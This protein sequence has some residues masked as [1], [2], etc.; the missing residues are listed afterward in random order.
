MTFTQYADFYLKIKAQEIK[1]SSFAK[2]QS[3]VKYYMLP[4]FSSYSIKEA[5]KM[6]T[7][8][9]FLL[10]I[11]NL[12]PK[13]AVTPKFRKDVILVLRG[14]LQEAFYDEAIQKN[15]A[16]LIR[17][18]KAQKPIINPFASHEVKNL[19][20]T[21]HGYFK[22]FLAVSFYTGVRTG[23]AMALHVSDI[24]FKNNVIHI[25]KT[26]GKYGESTPKTFSS[27]RDVPLF[28]TL[29]PFLIEYLKTHDNEY[30]FVNQYGNPFN[31]SKNLT[32]RHFHPLLDK[33][34]LQRR[35]LY[36]TRHTFAT[37]MLESGKFSVNEIARFMGHT[38]TQ[39]I[40]NRY[41]KFIE[42]ERRKVKTNVDIYSNS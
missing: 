42:S 39:M 13:G 18:I 8:R 31:C 33:L 34:H 29:K 37:N 38:N 36:E 10:E 2:Y 30:L 1:K 27:I 16:E 20:E 4:F 35:R 24:D 19:L 25:T 15:N 41:T 40:F 32:F 7:I 17:P 9:K 6:H 3:I 28:D 5:N 12:S 23:E 26:R 22:V 14:I 21:S 11:D